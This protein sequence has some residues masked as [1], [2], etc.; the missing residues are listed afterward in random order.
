MIID[1]GASFDDRLVTADTSHN[2]KLV[3]CS[4]I[5]YGKP[6]KRN[7]CILFSSAKQWFGRDSR[8]T[9]I[10]WETMILHSAVH[11]YKDKTC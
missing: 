10:T 1:D 11:V 5:Q 2:G 4:F 3:Y 7:I 8:I 6:G 9:R